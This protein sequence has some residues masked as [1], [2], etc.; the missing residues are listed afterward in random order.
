MSKNTKDAISAGPEQEFLLH[1]T[2]IYPRTVKAL[3]TTKITKLGLLFLNSHKK[4]K[5]ILEG[6]LVR[7]LFSDELDFPQIPVHRLPR[8]ASNVNIEGTERGKQ[9]YYL[10]DQILGAMIYLHFILLILICFYLII[11]DINYAI[12]GC[13]SSR[14]APGA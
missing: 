14:T 8:N 13:S 3:Q 4:Q 11:P 5:Y 7:V 10:C 6:K 12:Y 2:T 9:Q 1:A